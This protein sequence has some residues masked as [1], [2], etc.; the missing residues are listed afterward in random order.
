MSAMLKA[1]TK[2]IDAH[3]PFSGPTLLIGA[4][5]AGTFAAFVVL[6]LRQ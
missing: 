4:L 3:L 6:G 1:L 2:Q 5:W